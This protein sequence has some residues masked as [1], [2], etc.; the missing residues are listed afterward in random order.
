MAPR[1][2]YVDLARLHRP[3]RE[4]LLEAT[5]RVLDHGQFVL[6]P[7]VA[8]LEARLAERLGVA[9]VVGVSTGTDA[10]VLALRLA[11]VGQGDEVITVSHSF[12]AT[13]SAIRLLGARPVF[14][15]VDE[16]TMLMDPAGLEAARSPRTRAVLPV[17]LNGF[18]CDLEPIS[19]FCRRHGLPLIE[20]CAQAFGVLHAGRPVGST[21][22]GCFSLHPL[23]TLSACGDAGFVSV[24]T[25]REAELLRQWRNLGLR[26]RDHC[27]WV[28]G[29]TRLDGLQ[30][31]L[32][33]VK[34][35][36][37]DRWVEARRAHAAA[38]RAALAGRVRL[39]PA[40]KEGDLAI[41]SAFPI[42]H[43]HR[44]ALRE[45]LDRRGVDARAHYPLAIHQQEAFA[46][47]PAQPLP[48]T[49]RVVEEILSLPVGPELT[50]A[51][52][53]RVIEA[54]HEALDEVEDR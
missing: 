7:E 28:S 52:R 40:E 8:E 11:G 31:A 10:L 33:S 13:A 4:E 26:D 25:E 34:L 46:D 12:V 16:E 5:A 42:R 30:A 32:A 48:V 44:D 50:E 51:G 24:T 35:R 15:D 41:Y 3:L 53:K 9:A 43:R 27:R 19:A 49:E 18:A 29:N 6:G 37:F 14:V 39:P 38:Y 47:L 20:D 36:H 45:A 1:I 21:Q 23:K 54:V 17:H 22:I 2:P